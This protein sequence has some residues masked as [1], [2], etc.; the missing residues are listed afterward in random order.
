MP[1]L[2]SLIMV[3]SL[4]LSP[5]VSSA[6]DHGPDLE[7]QRL[8]A[9]MVEALDNNESAFEKGLIWSGQG[10]GWA[11]EF[12]V[13]F[14]LSQG[15]QLDYGVA[16]MEAASEGENLPPDVKAVMLTQIGDVLAQNRQ[17]EAA[18]IRYD[19]ALALE[20]GNS[21]LWLASANNQIALSHWAEALSASEAALALNPQSPGAL[22]VKARALLALGRRQEAAAALDAALTLYPEDIKLLVLRG[23]IREA[24]RQEAR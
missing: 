7:S 15:H 4:T 16:R 14:A 13:G 6:P 23:D 10:G 24:Q 11:A 3:Q 2:I 12:C 21:E 8:R 9:C 19:A 17:F 20:I 5:A 22:E 1:A 18:Q